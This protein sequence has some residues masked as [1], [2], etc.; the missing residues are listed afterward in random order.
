VREIDNEQCT[1]YKIKKMWKI[2]QDKGIRVI[3]GISFTWGGQERPLSRRDMQAK[4]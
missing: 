2:N 3:K 4:I 1:Y